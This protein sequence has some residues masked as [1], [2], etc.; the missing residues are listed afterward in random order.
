MFCTPFL[1]VLFV[2][3]PSGQVPVSFDK[4]PFVFEHDFLYSLAQFVTGSSSVFTASDMEAPFSP[5]SPVSFYWQL[6]ILCPLTNFHL[7]LN[8]S[9]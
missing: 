3:A 1:S 4:F 6:W 5:K 7:S 2:E 9:L 8:T